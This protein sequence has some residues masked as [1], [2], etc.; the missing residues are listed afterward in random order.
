MS[1]NSPNNPF[2]REGAESLAH[3]VRQAQRAMEEHPLSAVHINQG[4]A[5]AMADAYDAEYQASR[6]MTTPPNA[7]E[8]DV[9]AV[10][11]LVNAASPGPWEADDVRSDG[12][13]GD[14]GP[15]SHTGFMAKQMFDANGVAIFDSL[16][17]EV[18]EVDESVDDEYGSVSAWDTIADKNFKAAAAAV[19]FI[20]KHGADIAELLT[21]EAALV[22]ERDAALRSANIAEA[23]VKGWEATV[24]ITNLPSRIWPVEGWG[25]GEG[26]TAAVPELTPKKLTDI[27]DRL[28]AADAI[29]DQRDAL[30]AK[31]GALTSARDAYRTMLW[32]AEE[33]VKALREDA[34][35]WREVER[36][37]NG[38]KTSAASMALEGLGLEPTPYRDFAETVDVAR[39]EPGT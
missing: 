27:L 25:P 1:T 32:Q 4:S 3:T 38:S 35:R 13:Y 12:E 21:R 2:S 29:A 6:T 19:N 30:A 10:L 11:K 34:E 33:D 31:V 39:A 18:S 37:F 5:D 9:L 7:P 8:V 26:E 24:V 28:K 23:R 22:A 15:D 20:R 17:A 14:G 16:N 36:R